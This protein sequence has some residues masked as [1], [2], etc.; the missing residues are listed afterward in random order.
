MGMTAEEVHENSKI[1]PWFIDQFKA[2]VDT[3]ARIREHGLPKDAENLRMLKAMGF[4]DARLA[5]L[6]GR[7]CNGRKTPLGGTKLRRGYTNLA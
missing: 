6:T 7:F 1:D 2:I 5:S 4:S 3:E